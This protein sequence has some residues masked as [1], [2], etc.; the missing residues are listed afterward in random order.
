MASSRNRSAFVLGALVGATAGAAAAF[1]YA[2]QPGRV[3]R[4]QLQQWGER[5]IFAALDM[6]PYQPAPT[7]TVTSSRPAPTPDTQPPVDM[8]I[9]SRPSEI[10]VNQTP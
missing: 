3:T 6:V 10:G 5:I 2:P 1:W 4:D 9:G 7:D 8:V